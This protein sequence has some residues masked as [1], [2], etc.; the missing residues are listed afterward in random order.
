MC[1]KWKPKSSCRCIYLHCYGQKVWLYLWGNPEPI[2][3][4]RILEEMESAARWIRRPAHWDTPV[5]INRQPNWYV[6]NKT[7]LCLTW[8]TADL[9]FHVRRV[10]PNEVSVIFSAAFCYKIQLNSSYFCLAQV[11]QNW[12]DICWF[13]YDCY[14]S[15][16][17]HVGP[18]SQRTVYVKKKCCTD[19]WGKKRYKEKQSKRLKQERKK[20][21]PMTLQLQ[22]TQL[23]LSDCTSWPVHG[24]GLGQG[25]KDIGTEPCNF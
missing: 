13:V 22:T 14:L 9:A 4:G 18:F 10:L 6:S 11:V 2:V 5:C 21:F 19:H 7:E 15:S 25:W 20:H 12:L 24:K 1:W 16:D 17:C 8:I 3:V 23:C